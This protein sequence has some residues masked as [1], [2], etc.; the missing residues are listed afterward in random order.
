MIYEDGIFVFVENDPGVLEGQETNA[1]SGLSELVTTPFLENFNNWQENVLTER[2]LLNVSCDHLFESKLI[3]LGESK[4]FGTNKAVDSGNVRLRDVE[5]NTNSTLATD[6]TKR[7]KNQSTVARKQFNELTKKA[8]NDLQE[9]VDLWQDDQLTFRQLQVDSAQTFRDV[10]EDVW[11]LGRKASAVAFASGD[12]GATPEE[13]RWFRTAIREEMGFWQNFLL[14]LRDHFKGKRLL[15]RFTPNQRIE[16]YVK[17]LESMYDS[18]RALALPSNLLFYWI[19][20][21][22]DDPTTCLTGLHS[23]VM[24]IDGKVSLCDVVVGDYVLTH[25]GQWKRVT[26]VKINRSDASHRYAV[27]VGSDFELFGLTQDHQVWTEYGWVEAKEA[28]WQEANVLSPDLGRLQASSNGQAVHSDLLGRNQNAVCTPLQMAVG[29]D[30]RPDSRRVR[31]SSQKWEL[32]GRHVGELGVDEFYPPSRDARAGNSSEI[33]DIEATVDLRSVREAVSGCAG[34]STTVELLRGVP[35]QTYEER[36]ESCMREMRDRD[37]CNSISS[38]KRKTRRK[39]LLSEVLRQCSPQGFHGDPAV[40]LLWEELREGKRPDTLIHEGQ[41]LLLSEVLPEGSELYDLTVEDDH[42]FVVEG[43][44][45]HN[46]EGCAYIMERTPFTKFNLPAVPRSGSTPC[47]QNCFLSGDLTS[48]FTEYG[49]KKL[50]NVEVGELVLG[51][52]Q[53]FHKVLS[54][55]WDSEESCNYYGDAYEVIVRDNLQGTTSKFRVTPNHEWVTPQASKIVTT[56]LAVGTKLMGTHKQCV[57][58]SKSFSMRGIWATY[59]CCSKSCASKYF[60]KVDVARKGWDDLAKDGVFSGLQQGNTSGIAALKEA[61]KQ[62]KGKTDV[63]Y[64]GADKAAEMRD[65][66]SRTWASAARTKAFADISK[67]GKLAKPEKLMKSILECMG[68]RFEQQWSYGCGIADF[69]LPD[70]NLVLE[71]DGV[72]W[73]SKPE[74]V[75]RDKRQQEYLEAE[76]RTVIHVTDTELKDVSSV[77]ERLVNVLSNHEGLYLPVEF[78][79]VSIRKFEIHK[80]NPRTQWCLQVEGCESFVV[81]NGLVSGNCRHK[82]VVRKATPAQVARRQTALPSRDTMAKRLDKIVGVPKRL[83]KPRGK[84]KQVALNPYAKRSV[85]NARGG[86]F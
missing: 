53:R 8:K 16:M 69:Y 71:V 74:A 12:P 48:V 35:N 6:F 30:L 7:L 77:E 86:T 2:L 54:R 46:C 68:I 49:W 28:A 3:L 58:C 80:W 51:H 70:Y 31:D 85:R 44:A 42:S 21:K 50:C 10:Y 9:L 84:A 61:G 14:E 62:R 39:L 24:T 67:R 17:S 11:N 13:T 23:T 25:K 56:E 66:R 83:R 1:F 55:T 79:V 65:L 72:Y 38:E 43:R 76:G 41:V 81:N 26:D 29:E 40:R 19:G 27:V 47:L 36:S 15:P 82:L 63:D 22:R 75:T 32:I 33:C 5:V 60:S 73:H 45:I 34:D 59:S 78:E 64:Y 20:P 57:N 4:T 18:A 52:D 37:D